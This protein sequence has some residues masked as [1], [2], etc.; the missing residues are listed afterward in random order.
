MKLNYG[1][2]IAYFSQDQMELMREKVFELLEKHG[3]KMDH[4]EVLK[5]L[6]K[7]GAKVDFDTTMVR[8]PKPFLEEQLSKAPK[9]FAL[10]GK[11]G[12]NRMEFPHPGGLFYTRTNTGGQSFIEPETM[13]YRRVKLEDV[14]NWAKLVDKLDYIDFC[15]YLVPSDVPDPT[16]DVH[17]LRTMLQNI[18]KHIW[19]Q[20]YTGETV[21]YLV[22]LLVVAAGGEDNL[23]VNPL[24]DFITCSLSPLEMKY[25]DL[26][27]ILQSARHGVPLQP[28]SLPGAGATGPITTPA[29]VLL[30]SAENLAMLAIAQVIQPGLPIVATSLQF[31]TD[32]RTGRSLQSTVEALRQSALFVQFFKAA[33]GIP[34][35]TYGSGADSPDIDAQSMT[36]RALQTMLIAVSGADVLGAAGQIEVATTVS[37]VQLVIDNEVFGM[38]K[39]ILSEMIFDDDSMAWPELLNCKSGGEFLSNDHTLKHCRDGFTPI[40]F[41]QSAR[42]TWE[43][44][45]KSDLIARATDNYQGIMEKAEPLDLS[46]DVIREMDSIVNSADK[47]LVK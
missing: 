31:S 16:A 4:P 41:T 34:T 47:Q 40:N 3:M 1:S 8:F 35:H 11:D 25:M 10:V 33:F 14:A 20:P 39:G 2:R 12:K 30:S 13:N 21:E 23:R 7:S 5:I 29:S 28:C 27:I 46:K 17:A 19:I 36:E 32:M 42:D 18:E 43:A 22:K 45:R 37:P 9:Q 44:Q 38:V 24:A 15:P 26:E 6:D